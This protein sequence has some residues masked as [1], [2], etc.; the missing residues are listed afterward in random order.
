TNQGFATT[1]AATITSTADASGGLGGDVTLLSP[2]GAVSLANAP[3]TATA[4]NG[5]G[6]RAGYFFSI[7][8]TTFAISAGKGNTTSLGSN[9]N[10]GFVNILAGTDVGSVGSPINVNTS[11]APPGNG[12]SLSLIAGLSGSGNMNVNSLTSNSAGAAANVSGNIS[13]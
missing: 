11:A 8:G 9:A 1:G 12:G 10:A 7:A 13:V 3:S 5:T 2:A 6:S 4:G